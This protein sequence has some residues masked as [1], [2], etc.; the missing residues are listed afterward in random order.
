MP[1]YRQSK[2]YMMSARLLV[3][4][5]VGILAMLAVFTVLFWLPRERGLVT[6]PV[7]WFALLACVGGATYGAI[8]ASV[9]LAAAMK[10]EACGRRPTIVWTLKARREAP[11]S[12]WQALRDDFSPPELRARRFACAHC[13][14]KFRIS[15]PC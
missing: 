1:I 4:G 9:A 3:L 12:Q 5:R 15:C 8:I 6:P 2:L 10:C 11:R 14:T 7:W 13:G